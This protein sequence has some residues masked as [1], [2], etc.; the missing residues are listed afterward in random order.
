MPA[1]LLAPCR[2]AD[3]AVTLR[4]EFE[5]NRDVS[6]PALVQRLIADAHDAVGFIGGHIVQGV[7]NERGNLAVKIEEEQILEPPPPKRS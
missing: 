4:A 5:Q 6:D 7:M 3:P 2:P 1:L